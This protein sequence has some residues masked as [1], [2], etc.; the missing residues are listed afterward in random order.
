MWAKLHKGNIVPGGHLPGI[1]H[2]EANRTAVP[3]RSGHIF[4]ESASGE[5]NGSIINLKASNRECPVKIHD[6]V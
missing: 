6:F 3:F 4:F 5:M 1:L 2:E